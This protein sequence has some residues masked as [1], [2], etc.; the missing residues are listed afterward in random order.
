MYPNLYYAC[1]DLF[2]IELPFLGIINTAGFFVALSFIAGGWYWERGLRRMQA[3]GLLTSRPR[4]IIVGR[5]ARFSELLIA[6]ATGFFI[7]FKFGALFLSGQGAAN[8]LA[9]LFS[10]RGDWLWGLIIGVVF[11]VIRWW[12]RHQARLEQPEK[13]T[14]QEW[15]G[16][17]TPR[18]TILSA[19]IALVGAKIFAGLENWSAFTKDPVKA[20]LSPNGFVFYGGLIAAF[21][22][23]WL[24]HRRWG[25]ERVRIV[26]ALAPALLLAYALGRIGCHIS[27]DGDWGINNLQPNP[28]SWMPDWLW[29]YQYPHNILKQGIYM[30]GCDWGEYCYQLAVPVFPTPLY[31]FA[32]SILF[33]AVLRLLRNRIRTAGRIAALYLMMTGLGRLLIEQIRVNIAYFVGGISF[34][35]AELVSL[36][37]IISGLLLYIFAPRLSLNRT[38]VTST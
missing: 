31:E 16:D 38:A 3:A 29:A 4:T 19:L 18:V 23:M 15:P 9:F 13:R 26:D 7:G 14:I 2:G 11:T 6:F 36:L 37:L 10:L 12:G 25:P 30:K 27:G 24:Y 1:K 34:T 32:M 22:V 20:L 8:V 17:W 28:V 5:P 33:L 21:I 35:Q